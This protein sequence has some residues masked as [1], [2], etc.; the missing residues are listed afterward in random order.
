M[1]EM[2][3]LLKKHLA[4]KDFIIPLACLVG[5]PLCATQTQ[6]EPPTTNRDTV[7]MLLRL[8]VRDKK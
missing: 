5:A 2:K 7:L 6:S 8:P 4:G 3:A 1:R